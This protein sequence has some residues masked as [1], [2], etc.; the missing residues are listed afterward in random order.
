[1][2]C[3]WAS[4]YS[5]HRRSPRGFAAMSPMRKWWIVRGSVLLVAACA[6]PAGP[7]LLNT[8]QPKGSLRIIT[9]TSGSAPDP[10]G[11]AACVDPASD[12]HGGTSCAY[13]GP[14]A[15]WVNGRE[16]VIVDTGAHAVLLTGLAA[17]CTVASDNPRAVSV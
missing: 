9:G 16:T 4:A 17:N 5:T 2:E 13:D 11:Y 12:G 3:W 1:M 10:D 7:T 8:A 15:M 14:L 6:E